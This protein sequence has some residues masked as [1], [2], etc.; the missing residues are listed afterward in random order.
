[1]MTASRP[2]HS[3]RDYFSTAPPQVGHILDAWAEASE[4]PTHPQDGDRH[5]KRAFAPPGSTRGT[6]SCPH[7][8]QCNSDFTITPLPPQWPQASCLLLIGTSR[9]IERL[10]PGPSIG[11]GYFK[12]QVHAYCKHVLRDSNR[13]IYC[14]PRR[15]FNWPPG[16]TSTLRPTEQA[17]VFDISASQAQPLQLKCLIERRKQR[18]SGVENVE[19]K[20]QQV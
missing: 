8:G 20:K 18:G 14:R 6:H 16:M 1:P 2:P 17:V 3:A 12:F 4:R 9:H 15:G 7:N 5:R 19:A 11:R 13:M 10:M